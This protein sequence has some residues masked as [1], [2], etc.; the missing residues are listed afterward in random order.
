MIGNISEEILFLGTLEEKTLCDK[1]LSNNIC[2]SSVF[3]LNNKLRKH[4]P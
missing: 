4:K 3:L 1:N 2:E